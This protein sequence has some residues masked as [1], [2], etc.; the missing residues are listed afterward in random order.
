M[1]SAFEILGQIAASEIFTNPE[2]NAF[3]SEFS[4]Y[5]DFTKIKSELNLK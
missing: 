3:M 5:I 4:K 1:R 2:V